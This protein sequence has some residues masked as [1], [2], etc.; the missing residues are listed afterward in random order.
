M[1]TYIFYKEQY[2]SDNEYRQAIKEKKKEF[3]LIAKK[4]EIKE[5]KNKIV[6]KVFWKEEK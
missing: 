5:Y 6:F 2:K 4:L 1:R 3:L